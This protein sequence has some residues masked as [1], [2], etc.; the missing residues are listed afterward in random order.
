[1]LE[2]LQP[3]QDDVIFYVVDSRRPYVLDNVYSEAQ[4][5]LVVREGEELEL[6]AFQE[7]YD[8]DMVSFYI[9]GGRREGE[10]G[11]D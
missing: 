4:V 8:S 7:I 10:E 9:G 11:G 5:Q 6:P 2:L 1:M 3:E